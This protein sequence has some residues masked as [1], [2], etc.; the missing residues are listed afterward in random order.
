MKKDSRAKSRK[1]IVCALKNILS[2]KLY[3]KD[4][5]NGMM[6]PFLNYFFM[7]L[8]PTVAPYKSRWALVN[9]FCYDCA[10]QYTE[11]CLW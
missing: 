8:I 2:P 4:I 3:R 7:R 10:P 11:I 1:K 9:F 5:I 6:K